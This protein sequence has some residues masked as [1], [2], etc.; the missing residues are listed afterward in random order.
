VGSASRDLTP[1]DPRGW[2][3]GGAVTYAS[4]A[5]AGFGFEV[6]ALV[7]ADELAAGAQELDVLR[8]AGV[9]VTIAALGSGPVF[10]NVAHRLHATSDPIP[11]T[12]LPRQ[13]ATGVDAL[14]IAPVAAEVGGDWAA[15]AGDKPNLLVGLGWQGLLR[16]LSAGDL[17]RPA[18]PVPSP[19]VRAARL[20]VVSREDL[21]PGTRPEALLD[22]LRPEATLVWTEGADGGIVLG[23]GRDGMPRPRRYEAVPAAG[24]VDPTGA[25]DV[26]LAAMLAS[27]L[28]PELGDGLPDSTTFAAAAASLTVEGPGLLGVPDLA[29]T[30]RRAARAPS[31]AR[32]RASDASRPGVGRPSQA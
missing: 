14:L 21:A 30:L 24:V 16:S 5:L 28:R 12:A 17:I 26:F 15:P 10:D 29:A 22:L 13:W 25:G 31:R 27:L 20:V 8:A 1:D 2:R 23:R 32:R 3:L 18:P 19:L 7:G 9:T 4:L 6:R 11:L